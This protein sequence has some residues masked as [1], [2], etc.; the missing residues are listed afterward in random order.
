MELSKKQR[1]FAVTRKTCRPPP[2]HKMWWW[3]NGYYGGEHGEC[4]QWQ[5]NSALT[6]GSTLAARRDLIGIVFETLA[7]E[8]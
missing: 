3:P 2:S 6:R 5:Y 7:I 1:V 4:Q 8:P